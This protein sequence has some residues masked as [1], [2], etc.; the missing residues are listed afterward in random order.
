MDTKTLT[1]I[2]C[3]LAGTA[4]LLF[5]ILRTSLPSQKRWLFVY[6]GLSFFVYGAL[7]YFGMIHLESPMIAG[8]WIRIA[9]GVAFLSV[10]YL[11]RRRGPG[12]RVWMLFLI[13][14]ICFVLLGV[15]GWS[16]LGRTTQ[17]RT[18]DRE[19]KAAAEASRSR[20]PGIGQ[21]EELL[22]H[23][24]RIRT[25]NAPDAVREALAGYI[26]ALHAAIDAAKAGEDLAKHD[27][28][29]EQGQKR[30]AAAINDNWN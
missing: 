10:A 17:T 23:L 9:G 19:L 30:L 1:G 29:L 26:S 8:Q 21:F 4:S 18:I 7:E 15:F 14:G 12:R 24:E 5:G 2:F 16:D 28:A 27:R 20:P 22:A 6:L 13:A 11:E 3:A 25:E